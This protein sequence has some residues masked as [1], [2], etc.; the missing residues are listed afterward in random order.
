M[1]VCDLVDLVF[2]WLLRLQRQTTTS[3][4][5]K[6]RRLPRNPL[7]RFDSACP[8]LSVGEIA[9][10]RNSY[11]AVGVAFEAKVSGFSCFEDLCHTN[12]GIRILGGPLTDVDEA[13]AVNYAPDINDIYS[14]SWGPEDDGGHMDGPN[15]IVLNAML[16]GILHGRRGL[17]S[18]FV[19]AT[20]NG[21]YAQDDCNFDG[22]TN[23]IYTITIGAI[24]QVNGHPEYSETCSCQLAV[25]YSGGAGYGI[26]SFSFLL[27]FVFIVNLLLF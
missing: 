11:C 16:N 6:S 5:A 26:V 15:G 14:C 21:G 10:V 20:G 9:A 17:G 22:Y 3:Q 12:E 19:F 1:I 18:L 13:L 2:V 27:L 4:P 23:S 7:C 8:T 24:D 25:S